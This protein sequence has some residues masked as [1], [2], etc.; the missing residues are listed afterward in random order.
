MNCRTRVGRWVGVCLG[1]CRVGS[2]QGRAGL[3]VRQRAR[4]TLREAV[5]N[6]VAYE[7]HGQETHNESREDGDQNDDR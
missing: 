3:P 7:A 4:A 1:V 5:V 2:D 6:E